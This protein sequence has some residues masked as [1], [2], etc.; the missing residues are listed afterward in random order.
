MGA[1]W[2][3]EHDEMA[4]DSK[5]TELALAT[6]N[7]GKQRRWPSRARTPSYAAGRS[8]NLSTTGP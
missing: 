3:V 1:A 5:L 8:T 7:V 2:R 6:V 4:R